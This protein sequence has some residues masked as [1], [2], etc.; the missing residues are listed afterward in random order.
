MWAPPGVSVEDVLNGR[1]GTTQTG[2]AWASDSTWKGSRGGR[3]VVSDVPGA[4]ERVCK[5]QAM[6]G[7]GD[8]P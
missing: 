6:L 3:E 2:N 1:V 5:Q 7:P 8:T 4:A